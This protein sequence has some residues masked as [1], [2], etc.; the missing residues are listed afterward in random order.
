MPAKIARKI[1][2]EALQWF[3][4]HPGDLRGVDILLAFD[5]SSVPREY[6]P[7]WEELEKQSAPIRARMKE[8][9]A[10]PGAPFNTPPG[11]PERME[12]A[13]LFAESQRLASERVRIDREVRDRQQRR[14]ME[15]TDP[16]WER[17]IEQL[18]RIDGVTVHVYPRSEH[19]V[20]EVHVSVAA[21]TVTGLY[22]IASISEV[23]YVRLSVVTSTFLNVSSVV[24]GAQAVHA[25]VPPNKGDGVRVAVLDTGIHASE[26]QPHP[27]M[28]PIDLGLRAVFVD[29][30]FMVPPENGYWDAFNHGTAVAGVIRNSHPLYVAIAPNCTLVNAKC[31]NRYGLG[32]IRWTRDAARWAITEPE[33]QSKVVNNSQGETL[34]P[35]TGDT[36]YEKWLDWRL[37]QSP[38]VV[39]AQGAGNNTNAP[40]RSPGGA[41]NCITVNTFDDHGTVAVGDDTWHDGVSGPDDGSFRK[42]DLSAPGWNITTARVFSENSGTT[43]VNDW[44]SEAVGT[45]TSIATPHVAA[46]AALVK[47]ALPAA[48]G[49]VTKAIIVHSVDPP[50]SRALHPTQFGLGLRRLGPWSPQWGWGEVN[51]LRA[52]ET[53]QASST[54][55]RQFDLA[56]SDARTFDL[57]NIVSPAQATV[58][59]CWMRHVEDEEPTP[60]VVPFS[61]VNL[62]VVDGGTTVAGDTSHGKNSVKKLYFAVDPGK[63]YTVRVSRLST[64]PPG[65]ATETIVLVSS[66]DLSSV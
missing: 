36:V 33:I 52:V 56:E 1:D 2:P 15:L 59:V 24:I 11:S 39:W 66:H 43:L 65:V 16:I 45:G 10:V 48:S 51:A 58:T 54:Y 5:Y 18:R 35:A 40:V 38:D 47:R 23:G 46:T 60:V 26:A 61:H 63:T 42:P 12:Y 44:T 62:E 4:E 9:Q 17:V 30:G 64:D 29:P 3:Q 41:Y 19:I 8:L 7:E 55:I 53:A 6:P 57:Q 27:Q 21:R 31:A 50:R 13:R 25:M 32:D 34:V 28:A 49:L 14:W 22:T 20:G 37:T